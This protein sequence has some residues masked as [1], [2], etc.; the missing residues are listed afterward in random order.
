[1]KPSY[2][3][4]KYLTPQE[5]AEEMSVSYWTVLRMIDRRQI[6]V[7]SLPTERYR[8][9]VTEIQRIMTPVL[10]TAKAC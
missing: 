7:V 9:P 5:A 8:I 4:K 3:N 1:M 2:L 10:K 6:A